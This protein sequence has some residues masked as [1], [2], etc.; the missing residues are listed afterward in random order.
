MNQ[1][2]NH[3]MGPLALSDLIGLDTLYFI[4]NSIYDEFKDLRNARKAAQMAVNDAKEVEA[5]AR[6]Q[7]TGAKKTEAELES[8]ANRLKRRG[9][10]AE[11]RLA[12]A[13][14]TTEPLES[15][16]RRSA[17]RARQ[18]EVETGQR[19]KAAEKSLNTQQAIEKEFESLGH[20]LS[21]KGIT[22]NKDIPSEIT[23]LADRLF[24][25]NHISQE[26]RNE[27]V[28]LATENEKQWQDTNKARRVL[29]AIGTAIGVPALAYKF[30]GP[31]QAGQ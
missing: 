28:R 31:G 15:V 1:G 10:L 25:L 12:E 5:G 26:E 2:F 18:F 21:S 20:D 30:Y 19:V 23:S 3:P 16:L 9:N 17:S 6:Q 29:G 4:A 14:K 27:M 22:K 11:S 8:E 7:L 13:L 24:K